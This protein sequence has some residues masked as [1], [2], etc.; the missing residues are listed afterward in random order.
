MV[1]VLE[2]RKDIMVSNIRQHLQNSPYLLLSVHNIIMRSVI[3]SKVDLN[4]NMYYD[5][6]KDNVR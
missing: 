1:H 4:T 6:Y 3:V 5:N 2:L